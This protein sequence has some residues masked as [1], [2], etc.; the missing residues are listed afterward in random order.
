MMLTARPAW[1]QAILVDPFF[2]QIYSGGDEGLGNY[3][4]SFLQVC[5]PSTHA[6]DLLVRLLKPNPMKRLEMHSGSGHQWFHQQGSARQQARELSNH[7]A[8]AYMQRMIIRASAKADKRESIASAVYL[9]RLTS[10]TLQKVSMRTQSTSVDSSQLGFASREQN[11]D[12]LD[13]RVDACLQS[14]CHSSQAQNASG[15]CASF[16]QQ[17][18]EAVVVA[19]RRDPTSSSLGNTLHLKRLF[20]ATVQKAAA[21]SQLSSVDLLKNASSF[22]DEPDEYAF[23]QS[24]E[25]CSQ[26]SYSD[27][28]DELEMESLSF[29]LV[30][31]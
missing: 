10:T 19:E 22:S 31:T 26:S 16:R 23:E 15:H 6:M 3:I 18:T 13:Q 21:R 1:K 7:C 29:S 8:S 9:R 11:E 25:N 30:C 4:D 12:T 5:R 17:V 27:S 20:V 2:R 28:S 24:T 14:S